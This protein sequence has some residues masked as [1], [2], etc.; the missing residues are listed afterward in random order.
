MSH[1][2]LV[3]MNPI[4]EHLLFDQSHRQHNS[5]SAVVKLMSLAEA[6]APLHPL[7]AIPGICDGTVSLSSWRHATH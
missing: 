4:V 7:V 6:L 5:S 1:F 2:P 3:V